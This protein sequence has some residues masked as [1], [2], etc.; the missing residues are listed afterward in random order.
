MVS[1]QPEPRPLARMRGDR[2]GPTS[3]AQGSIM[4]GKGGAAGG[5]SPPRTPG[6]PGV[7]W[8]S[9]AHTTGTSAVEGAASCSWDGPELIPRLAQDV[10]IE[11]VSE[12]W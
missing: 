1:R 11:E 12:D 10:L 9:E 4:V 7:R 3:R 2:L 8:H 6:A 5:P